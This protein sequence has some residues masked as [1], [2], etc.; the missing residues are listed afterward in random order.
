[1]DSPHLQFLGGTF[2][3]GLG[4]SFLVVGTLLALGCVT[5]VASVPVCGASGGP[6]ARAALLV[7]IGLG[8][9]AVGGRE[10]LRAWRPPR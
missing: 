6:L 10:T 1:M 2:G 7:A 8:S 5:T 9:T 3:L 4:A